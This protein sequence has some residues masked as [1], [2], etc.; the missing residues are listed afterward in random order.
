MAVP[1]FQV[2]DLR[3]VGQRR[4]RSRDRLP[5]DRFGYVASRIPRADREQFSEADQAEPSLRSDRY[6]FIKKIIANRGPWKKARKPSQLS[7]MFP[8]HNG[9][10]ETMSYVKVGGEWSPVGD[11]C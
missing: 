5:W 10:C 11:R 6:Y 3:C 1:R 4:R 8:L 2:P 7:H 9:L